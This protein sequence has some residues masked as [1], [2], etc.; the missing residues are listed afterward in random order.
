MKKGSELYLATSVILL[1]SFVLFIYK[2]K[3]YSVPTSAM[4]LTINPGDLILVDRTLNSPD[5]VQRNDISIFHFPL[6]DTIVKEHPI[7]IYEQMIRDVALEKNVSK[8]QARNIINQNYTLEAN[9]LG[10][11]EHYVKRV[12]AIAGDVLEI[13]NTKLYINGEIT[14]DVSTTQYEYKVVTDG[15]RLS[16]DLLR[17]RKITFESI[18]HLPMDDYGNITITLSEAALKKLKRIVSV[19]SV[20][21][22]IKPKGYEYTFQAYPIFPNHKY[23]DWS[24]DNFGPLTIPKKGTVVKL[25]LNNLP[26]Y[27]RIISVYEENELLVNDGKIFINNQESN[28]Y[29]FK[30]NYYWMMGDNR[31]NSQDSRYWGFVPEDHLIGEMISKLYAAE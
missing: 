31:H 3:H 21:K 30:M 22:I 20:E 7:R 25:S 17:K 19:E 4:S 8:D 18:Y 6:G 16:E 24:I 10:S 14:E 9:S 5:D 26:L 12:V 27:S 29:R 13:K 15:T 2:Y 28:N 23:Y 1:V 11:K